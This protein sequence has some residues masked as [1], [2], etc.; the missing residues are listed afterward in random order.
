[1]DA[2]EV[3]VEDHRAVNRA[4]LRY[5]DLPAGATADRRE[6]IEEIKRRLTLHTATEQHFLHPVIAAV[7]PNGY[8]IVS[9]ELQDHREFARLARRV[10]G[11]GSDEAAR[12]LIDLARAHMETEE[13]ALF[14]LLRHSI[15]RADLEALGE[16][17]RT[18]REGCG[19]GTP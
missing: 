14:P 5:E 3:L 17:I 18:A 9:G 1:M 7:L 2:I 8:D 16:R 13:R 6:A 4:F 12:R 19:P 15:E 11:E 10:E